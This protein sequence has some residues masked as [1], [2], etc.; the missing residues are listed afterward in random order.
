MATEKPEV[1]F[2]APCIIDVISISAKPQELC[3]THIGRIGINEWL[4]GMHQM[5]TKY[6][7][8]KGATQIKHGLATVEM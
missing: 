3:V 8:R 6:E 2:A 4:Y 7:I 1:W 5:Q